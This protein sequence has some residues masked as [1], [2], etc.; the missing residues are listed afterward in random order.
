MV[1]QVI[2]WTGV[3]VVIAGCISVAA[4][5][6]IGCALLSNRAQNRLLESYGGWKIFREYRDWYHENKRVKDAP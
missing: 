3:V 2:Y 4:L 1:E 6:L 5:A